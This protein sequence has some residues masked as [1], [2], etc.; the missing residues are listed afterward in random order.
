MHP[1]LSNDHAKTKTNQKLNKSLARL[2]LVCLSVRPS[3]LFRLSLCPF[4]IVS[5]SDFPS[6]GFLSFFS[7]GRVSKIA[8]IFLLVELRLLA[9]DISRRVSCVSSHIAVGA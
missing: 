5:F 7:F 4:L 6:F 2:Y 8:S 9:I 1:E 3:R